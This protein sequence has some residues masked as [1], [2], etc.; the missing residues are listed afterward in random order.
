MSGPLGVAPLV[1]PPIFVPMGFA[2]LGDVS[3][4]WP[5]AV[6]LG[7]LAGAVGVVAQVPQREDQ[8]PAL[9]ERRQ[10]L[11]GDIHRQP[12]PEM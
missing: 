1:V 4:F 5:C 3:G 11:G 10:P 12:F 6:L 9:E 7:E 8:P 2:D